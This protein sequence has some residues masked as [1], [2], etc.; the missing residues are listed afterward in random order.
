MF[1]KVTEIT[2]GVCQIIAIGARV[3]VLSEG[4][5]TPTFRRLGSTDC[6]YGHSSRSH[7]SEAGIIEGTTV[8]HSP[9]R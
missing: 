2:D 8:A 5:L 6:G 7:S 9:L 3:T 4:T 1:G